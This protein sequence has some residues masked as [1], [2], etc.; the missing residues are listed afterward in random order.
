MHQKRIETEWTT[1]ERERERSR[2]TVDCLIIER[3]HYF[4]GSV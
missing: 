3:Q 1:R 2:Q 4:T